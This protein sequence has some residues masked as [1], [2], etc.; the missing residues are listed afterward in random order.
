MPFNRGIR[1]SISTTR[2]HNRRVSAAAATL[3]GGLTDYLDVRLGVQQDPDAARKPAPMSCWLWAGRTQI[4]I[5]GA[6]GSTRCGGI[7]H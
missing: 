1:M 5:G 4:V 2:G 6:K 7:H 3:V